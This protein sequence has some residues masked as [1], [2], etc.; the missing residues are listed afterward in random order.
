MFQNAT[1]P[2]KAPTLSKFQTTGG[3][4]LG[5]PQGSTPGITRAS[6]MTAAAATAGSWLDQVRHRTEGTPGHHAWG[7][8]NLCERGSPGRSPQTIERVLV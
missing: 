8:W 7:G 5:S 4:F 2:K 1:D 6:A 3:S